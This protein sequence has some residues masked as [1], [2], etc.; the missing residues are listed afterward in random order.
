MAGASTDSIDE[1]LK[2]TSGTVKHLPYLDVRPKYYFN[3][4]ATNYVRTGIMTV[5]K[6]D[7]IA[8]II[9]PLPTSL[10]DNHNITYE[11][12]PINPF[13]GGAIN[14]LNNSYGLMRPDTENVGTKT[15]A[16]KAAALLTPGVLGASTIAQALTGYVPNEFMT[17]LLR[18]PEYKKH[19]FAWRLSPKTPQEARNLQQIIMHLNNYASPGI[20][21][22]GALFTFPKIFYLAFVPNPQ[23]MYKFKPCVIESFVAKYAPAGQPSFHRAHERTTGLNAPEGIDIAIRFLELEYWLE[24]DYKDTNNPFDVTDTADGQGGTISDLIDKIIK[25]LDDAEFRRRAEGNT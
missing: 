9:L 7:P 2:K 16:Q 21:A 19:E 25:G 12:K 23:Y 14:S 4:M 6:L 3:I 1:I 15:N 5:G 13:L 18:G 11:Q 8:N 24:G 10:D 20:A 17:V 22:F